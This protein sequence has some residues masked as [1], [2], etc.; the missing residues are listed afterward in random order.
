LLWE[1]VSLRD[2]DESSIYRSVGGKLPDEV[3]QETLRRI[4]S[5]QNA[6]GG[7][8][9]WP[10]GSSDLWMT[11]YVVFT[12][13]LASQP[14]SDSLHRARTHLTQ[15][16]LKRNHSDDADVFAAFALSWTGAAISDRVLAVLTSRW[17]GLSLTGKAKL[18]WVLFARGHERARECGEEV[19]KALVGPAKRFLKK[20]A[21]DDD[22]DLQWFHPG[23]TEAIA[24]FVLALLR[25]GQADSA[26]VSESN[27]QRY[28]LLVDD[29]TLEVLVSFLLQH[30]KGARWHNTRDT[31][32]AVLALLT[33]EDALRTMGPERQ[34]ATAAQPAR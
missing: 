24:F 19:T 20:V 3:V 8:G 21:R 13:A 16:L 34:V 30:R 2:D 12:F 15:H 25:E 6:D 33:Y 31:A 5:M 1:R 4:T 11:A 10:G 17:E 27:G 32:L 28:R 23:S 9:W 26:N 22:N 14:E 18:C 7:F 29:E